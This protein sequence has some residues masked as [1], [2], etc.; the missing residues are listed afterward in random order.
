MAQSVIVLTLCVVAAP[1]LWLN[2]GEDDILFFYLF[3]FIY[4]IDLL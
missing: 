2:A 4:L 1:S 3:C